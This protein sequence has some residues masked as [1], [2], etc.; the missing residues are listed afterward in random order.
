M[1]TNTV[2]VKKSPKTAVTVNNDK[3]I[4]SLYMIINFNE[5][6]V[7]LNYTF[8]R[9]LIFKRYKKKASHSWGR[10]MGNLIFKPISY[11]LQP[12]ICSAN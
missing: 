10:V 5:L 7:V 1:N 11:K 6:L 9:S 8:S 12:P 4:L 3:F 2:V